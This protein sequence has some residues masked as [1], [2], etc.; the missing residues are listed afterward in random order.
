ML[1]A[2]DSEP[3]T[4]DGTQA[5]LCDVCEAALVGRVIRWDTFLSKGWITTV[6]E[7]HKNHSSLP[8]PLWAKAVYI[9]PYR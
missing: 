6:P 2:G 5:P 4:M 3:G 8:H 7:Q 9:I 1:P